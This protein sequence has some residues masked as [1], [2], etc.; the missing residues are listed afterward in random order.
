MRWIFDAKPGQKS[1]ERNVA[2]RLRNGDNGA[3]IVFINRYFYPDHS[4]TSQI[5][6]DL[7]FHLAATRCRVCVITGRQ[8][9]DDAAASLPRREII[10]GV[11]VLRV[12]TT[13]FGRSKLPGRLLD[14]LS[15]Y[16]S[17][18]YALQ[19]TIRPGDLVIP[20][21]DPPMLSVLA[22]FVSR[23]RGARLVNWLQDLYPEIAIEHGVPLLSGA[24]G[25]AIRHLRDKSL[26]A[27]TANVV[28][29]ELM[30][31]RLIARGVPEDRV[32]VI[33]NWIDDDR[34]TPIHPEESR[35]RREWDLVGKFVIGYSGNLGRAHEF[36]TMLSASEE[37]RECSGLVFL[38][39]GGGYRTR[40]LIRAVKERGLERSY[41]FLPYQSNESLKESL[42]AADVHW[43]S[44]LPSM[45]GLIVPSKFYG[46]AAAGRPVI[47]ISSRFG[48]IAR[49]V[50]KHRCG[51]VID[52]GDSKGLARAIMQF[53]AN[54]QMVAE[55]GARSR[56]LMEREFSRRT[57]FERWA[58]LLDGI[59]AP[60]AAIRVDDP[61]ECTGEKLNAKAGVRS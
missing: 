2:R 21:T 22:G 1:K 30:R 33:A 46:I 11:E 47:V 8:L 12:A 52:I 25:T 40:D 49:Q 9:Y 54:P 42:G 61:V 41:R 19:R 53:R 56:E 32:Q 60:E 57:A 28:V 20:K 59:G 5:L 38:F 45:E 55:M 50:S 34:I 3:R 4:A 15:F 23:I 37:L 13:R 48:E 26:R 10:K 39:V 43:L 58:A 7:A 27:A 36:D 18:W 35:L 44:I 6:T 31:D 14:Y 29:G 51:L 17:V 16:L 24:F